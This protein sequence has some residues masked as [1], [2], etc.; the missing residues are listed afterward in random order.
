MSTVLLD[1]VPIG[2]CTAIYGPVSKS[3]APESSDNAAFED[4]QIERAI[5]ARYRQEAEL[6]IRTDDERRHDAAMRLPTDA[7]A[8]LLNTPSISKGK[9]KRLGLE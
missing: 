7:V 3:I 9:P 8:D 5:Y 4:G 1:D 2:S 6:E